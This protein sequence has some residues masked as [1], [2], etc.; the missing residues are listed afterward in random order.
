[1][2]PVHGHVLKCLNWIYSHGELEIPPG[3]L[4]SRPG[5]EREAALRTAVDH[6]RIPS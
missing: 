4:L 1:M 2:T 6:H 5:V 3:A